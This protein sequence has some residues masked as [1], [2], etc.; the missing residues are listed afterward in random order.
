MCHRIRGFASR[1][2]S[3]DLTLRSLWSVEPAACVFR[4]DLRRQRGLPAIVSQQQNAKVLPGKKSQTVA[5][6]RETL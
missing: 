1:R 3:Y 5:R 6:V 2:V 4:F